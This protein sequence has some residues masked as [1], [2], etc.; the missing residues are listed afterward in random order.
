VV[1]NTAMCGYQEAVTDP[2]YTGQIL[3]MTAP[4]IGNYGISLED[5]EGPSI[6]V[7][8][9]VIRDYSRVRS[10][11]RSSEHLHRWM[12]EAG[13]PGLEDL[14]TRAIVRMLR[15]DGAM[16]GVLESDPSISDQDL[17][18]RARGV[19]SMSGCNLAAKAGPSKPGVFTQ[20][21]GGWASAISER[22][23]KDQPL[24]VLALDCGAK[25]NIYR[26]LRSRGCEVQFIPHDTPAASIRAAFEDGSVHGLF[27]SNGPGDPAA[28]EATIRT[29]KEVAGEIP[30]FGICLG[31]QLLALAMGATTY[32]LKFGHRGAN[33]P[34]RCSMTGQVEITSQNHGFCVDE[35]SL[36]AAGAEVTHRHLNDGTVAGFRHLERPI[37]S[38]QYH[39]EAS[40]G[41]HESAY[42]FDA[43]IRMMKSRKP[44]QAIDLGALA[45]EPA[46][47][48]A[49]NRA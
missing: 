20:D 16:R 33:Q 23:A 48:L 25:R 29:L 31:H 1:F 45:S 15:N 19:A 41:P 2:S 6:A 24:V 11:Y 13:I 37:F 14:D 46:S 26:H 47:P 36:V 42:L 5:Q 43:F 39:P 4:E 3:V 40:P 12:A 21:L 18:A 22:A 49:P 38:V 35:A 28:V 7:A 17:V 27:V 9:L 34:V 10:N 44:L 32:K 30:T 8:G